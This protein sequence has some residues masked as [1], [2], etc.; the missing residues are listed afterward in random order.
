MVYH[1]LLDWRL[2]LAMLRVLRRGDYVAGLDG[3]FN[4][5]ELEGWLEFA[6]G[7]R[8]IFCV[9]F[10]VEPLLLGPGVPGFKAGDLT[11]I[12]A[13]PLWDTHSPDGILAEAR[14]DVATPSAKYVDTFNLLRRQSWVYQQLLSQ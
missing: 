10:P 7:L 1:S 6:T 8:D 4:L 3:N 12:I 5:P 9:A 14:A 2:G 13:H 11:V